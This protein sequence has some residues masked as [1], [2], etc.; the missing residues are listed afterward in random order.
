MYGL[1][2]E[3]VEWDEA[4]SFIQFN[5]NPKAKWSDGQPVT[6]EDVIFTFELLRDKGRTP[7]AKRLDSVAKME[8]VGERSVRFT[9]NDKADRETP[10]IL[11]LS[12]VL[13]KHATKADGFDQSSLSIPVGSGPYTIKSVNPGNS[14]SFQRNP[15]YW[16]KDLPSKVGFDNYDTINVQYFLQDTAL[17]EAFKKGDVDI[18]QEGSPTHWAR[19]YDFPAVKSGAVIKEEF[20]PGLPSGMF[21]FVFNTRRPV[22]SDIRVR[23]ALTLAFDFEWANK[24]LFENAYQRTQSFWQNSTLSSLNT[25]ASDAE[26]ALLGDTVKKIEPALLD[27]TW[28]LPV[29]DA[30]GRDRKL[31]KQAVDLLKSA[32]YAIKGSQMV[33]AD[34][35]PLTFEIMTQSPDQEKL[36]LAYQRSL[37]AI[38]VAVTIRTVDDSQYQSRSISFDYDMILKGFA[39]SLSPGVEQIG[40]WGSASKDRQGSENFAGVADPD[41]DRLIDALL[42]AK[43]DEEFQ[44]AIRAYDRL[45]ISGHYL[46]PLYH[47]PLQRVAYRA[48]IGH[49][50]SLPLYGVQL[51]TWWDNRAQ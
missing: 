6:P 44:T 21:G 1:L 33:S 38:G 22:F 11:A 43:S 47:T 13:P 41:V 4:R 36:A 14:I 50:A 26:K 2:A 5:L 39:S 24:N 16:A 20:K 32:G 30:S 12:P 19:G 25:P 18:Y 28:K 17:F 42:Q 29:S 34:G 23:E 45:L 10:L 8:K 31:L 49:P 15:D 9:F 46:V 3:T 7:F 27:G 51:S 37:R 35:K 48:T 40:R